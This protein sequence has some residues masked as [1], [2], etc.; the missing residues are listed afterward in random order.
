MKKIRIMMLMICSICAFT[1]C[2]D[3]DDPTPQ[4]PVS[5]VRIPATAESV[6]KLSYPVPDSLQ[7]HSS[8]SKAQPHLPM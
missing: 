6:R 1:A 3:D 4:N 8:P 2:S 5:N 7:Q